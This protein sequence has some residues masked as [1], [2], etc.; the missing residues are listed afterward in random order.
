METVICFIHSIAPPADACIEKY[1]TNLKNAVFRRPFTGGKSCMR[2]AKEPGTVWDDGRR[3]GKQGE[4]RA[5][6]D[7]KAVFSVFL[8]STKYSV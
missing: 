8:D 5:K 3:I 1:G 7:G 4:K 2:N 6:S